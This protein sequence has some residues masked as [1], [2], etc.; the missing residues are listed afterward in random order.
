MLII[1]TIFPTAGTIIHRTSRNDP[2]FP[3]KQGFFSLN[4]PRLIARTAP[5][6]KF[7]LY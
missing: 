6:R 5:S 1:N 3:W 2:C 4:S 7:I